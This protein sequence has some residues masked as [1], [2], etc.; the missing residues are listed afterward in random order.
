MLNLCVGISVSL[1]RKRKK[2]QSNDLII[3]NTV[4]V[5]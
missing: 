3:A 5:Q 4:D 1:Q 2:T